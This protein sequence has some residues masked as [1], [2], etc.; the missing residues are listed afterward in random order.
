MAGAQMDKPD[1][2]FGEVLARETVDA[3]WLWAENPVSDL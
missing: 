3:N 1:W 2:N